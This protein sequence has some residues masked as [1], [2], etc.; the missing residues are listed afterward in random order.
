[1][2]VSLDDPDSLPDQTAPA[3][4]AYLM[5][6]LTKTTRMPLPDDGVLKNV[7]IRDR[8]GYKVDDRTWAF[9]KQLA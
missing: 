6:L 5:V 1:M 2:D 7:R 3:N 8:F 9:Y 4:P